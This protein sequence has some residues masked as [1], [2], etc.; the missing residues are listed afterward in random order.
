MQGL[1][2]L[3]EPP[4]KLQILDGC[5]EHFARHGYHGL[6]MRR[7]AQKLGFTTGALYHHYRSKSELFCDLVS[8]H[9][10]GD[11][12][13]LHNHLE[14]Q[15]SYIE[16]A[17][18]LVDFLEERQ[19]YFRK[20]IMIVLDLQ[21]ERGM[22]QGIDAARRRVTSALQQYREFL[23]QEL[24]LSEPE[25]QGLLSLIIGTFVQKEIDPK[26]VRFS[27]LRNYLLALRM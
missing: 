24:D 21:R 13:A 7:L 25:S 9:S 19:L 1:S 22:G 3:G 26:R 11:I 23:R 14:N 6:S 2:A 17:S 8:F 10:K 16:Q 12:A 20:M 15:G 18:A 5:F 27:D 4:K